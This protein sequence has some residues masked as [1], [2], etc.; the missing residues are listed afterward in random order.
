MHGLSLG[1]KPQL[2]LGVYDRP[3]DPKV[4][5]EKNDKR[6]RSIS[7]SWEV[8]WNDESPTRRIQ[9]HVAKQGS[10]TPAAH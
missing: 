2:P 5:V 3:D 8:K 4:E 9:V 6:P 1:P 7:I 10:V